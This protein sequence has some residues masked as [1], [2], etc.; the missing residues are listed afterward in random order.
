[1][2]RTAPPLLLSASPVLASSL[3][4]RVTR[5]TSPIDP[6]VVHGLLDP[7]RFQ[8]QEMRPTQT[9]RSQASGHPN[10]PGIAA[11]PLLTLEGWV[12]CMVTSQ[13]R[14]SEICVSQCVEPEVDPC[15]GISTICRIYF[16][17]FL[18]CP[19]LPDDS[20]SPPYL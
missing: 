3:G 12:Y 2:I 19:T 6:E 16:L 9:P 20:E 15:L 14:S 18:A 7:D 13:R 17:R 4:S 11:P 1:L 8:P 5:S 10:R